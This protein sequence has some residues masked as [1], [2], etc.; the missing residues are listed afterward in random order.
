ML[1]A[2]LGTRLQGVYPSSKRFVRR[3]VAH[4]EGQ[5]KVI[6][7]GLGKNAMVCLAGDYDAVSESDEDQMNEAEFDHLSEAAF[8]QDTHVCYHKGGGSGVAERIGC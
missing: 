7:Y 5:N 1:L 6:R 4:L 2:N 8:A 3:L